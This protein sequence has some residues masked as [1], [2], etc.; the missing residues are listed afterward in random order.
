M[1]NSNNCNNG[2][3]INNDKVL[4]DRL[5]LLRNQAPDL[6]HQGL[7]GIERE[8]LRVTAQG[9][10]ARTPHP[11]ALGSALT[12]PHITTDYAEALLEFITPAQ[13]DIATVLEHLDASHRFTALSLQG[14][15]EYFW[16]NSMPCI[17]PRS[18]PCMRW[19]R[20]A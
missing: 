1:I 6:L 9:Q 19:R 7:R 20:S 2:N 12:H 18:M 15:D 13:P 14:E 3:N 17:L 16:A 4:R 8:T 5:A 11:S 10:L